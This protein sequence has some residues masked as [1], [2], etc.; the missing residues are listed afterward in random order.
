MTHLKFKI[1]FV[2]LLFVSMRGYAQQTCYQIGLNE[3]REIF[4]EAQKLERSG[5]C[6]EAVPRLTSTM[7]HPKEPP[8]NPDR[9]I[10][11]YS[12]V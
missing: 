1:A 12:C 8:R 3:G 10:C 9:T 7:R 4:N 6:V 11:L 5:R 2:L